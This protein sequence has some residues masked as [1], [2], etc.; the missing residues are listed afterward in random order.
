MSRVLQIVSSYYPRVG[1][2]EQVARDIVHVLHDMHLEQK[3]IC[4]NETA[5]ADGIKCKRKETVHDYVDGVEVIRCGAFTKIASQP[6]SVTYPHELRQVMQ[7]YQ[8]DVV[9]FHYPNPYLA[10]FF[11][12]YKKRDFKLIVYWHLDI[13]KQK[14]L[15][16]IFHMQ[17]MALLK[18][19]DKV[20]ATSPNYIEHSPYLRRFQNKCQVISCCVQT[21]RFQLTDPILERAKEIRVQNS[22]KILC[23]AVGRHVPYKGLT[24][25]IQASKFLPD[26][27]SIC[28]GGQGP[29]TAQLR[30]EAQG[31]PKISF[32]GRISD[33]DLMAYL[34]ACDIFCFP[35][36]TKNEAFGIALAE[37][38][39]FEKPSVTFTIP[40]SGVNY[41]NLDGVTGIECANGDSAAY[42]EALQKLAMDPEL[43]ETYGRAAKK[44]VLDHF[45]EKQFYEKFFDLFRELN[46]I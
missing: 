34:M 21:E 44:R 39:Y 8:P 9:I 32:L 30:Q 2:I 41:V 38:M 15:K 18:R 28:I 20:I 43:R 45:T 36:V 33:R 1:G 6:L 7:D 17:T 26:S 31:D 46:A 24:Y 42:A 25:L 10:E 22:G 29:L 12:K 19:A 5:E 40:G 16:Y 14:I 4:F 35:S 27:F 13:T 23:F 3:I 37:A 11:L